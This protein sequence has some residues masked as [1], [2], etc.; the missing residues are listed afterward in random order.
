MSFQLLFW[1]ILPAWIYTTSCEVEHLKLYFSQGDIKK[2]FLCFLSMITTYI[3][4]VCVCLTLFP[5]QINSDSIIV[6]IMINTLASYMLEPFLLQQVL[7]VC[8]TLT[9][10]QKF[11]L[12]KGS[13]SFQKTFRFEGK[14]SSE[15]PNLKGARWTASNPWSYFPV[16]L[17]VALAKTELQVKSID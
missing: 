15:V 2:L 10:T 6:K 8:C 4:C 16:G 11:D 17:I 12:T 7:D 13:I 14:E 5:V 9:I 3:S 1:S